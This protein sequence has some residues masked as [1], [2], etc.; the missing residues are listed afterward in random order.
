MKKLIYILAISIALFACN[1]S[2]DLT[3]IGQLMGGNF[4]VT[5]DDAIALTNGIYQPNALLSSTVGYLTDLPTEVE[6][7]GEN[8]T[9]GGG[10]V[11]LLQLDPSNEVVT[12][13]WNYLYTG[14]AAANNAIER[15]EDSNTISESVRKRS[16]GE[17]HFLRAYYY[18]YAVQFWGE[19][20]LPLTTTDGSG[21]TRAAVDDVYTQIVTDLQEAASRLPVVSEY[22]SSDKGRATQGAANALL[23]KVYLTWGQ[24]SETGGNAAQKEK[25][26]KAIDAANLVTGYELEEVYLANWSTAIRNGKEH[27]FTTQHTLSQDVDGSGGNHLLHCSLATGFTQIIPHVVVSDL[28]F[29]EAFDDRDQRKKGTYA[30]ELYNPDG[31]SIFTFDLPRFRKYIDADDPYGSASNRN[32]DRT[33]IRYAEVLLLKAEAINEYN[34]A[35]NAEAY[36]A[37]NQILRRAFGHFPVTAQSVDDLSTGLDYEGFKRV[38]QE[39][40]TF[41]L[42]Y[43]QNRWTDLVRWRI[44]VKTLK[45]SGVNPIYGKQNVSLKNYRYPIPQSQR[46]INPEGLWQ[47]WGFDGANDSKTGTNPYAGFE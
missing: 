20:P 43:E 35:P 42:T 1:D 44:Y 5:D 13:V 28:K 16:I 14:I 27:I 45:N 37:V 33:V 2:L 11:S 15:I 34:G 18:F 38:I 19:V 30:K 26:G 12:T 25:F 7:S 17:A 40:R 21:R 3:P 4:P 39:Q 9:S 36:E 22:S 8:P 29:Y 31:D 47:N 6:I 41:E 10:L 23:A 46:N 24:T 32:I